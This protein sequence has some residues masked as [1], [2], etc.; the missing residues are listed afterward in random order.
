MSQTPDRDVDSWLPGGLKLASKESSVRLTIFWRVI[1]AQIALIILI[2]AVNFYALSQLNQLTSQSAAIVSR[3][4]AC[5]NEAKRLLQVFLAQMR[6]AEK[7]VLLQDKTFYNHFVDANK[8]FEGGITRLATLIDSRQE[9][10]LLGRI[11]QLHSRYTATLSMVL[12]HHLT[13]HKDR[14]EIGNGIAASLDELIRAREEAI[15]RKMASAGDQ[16]SVAA[17]VVTWLTFGG[18]SL[19]VIFAYFHARSV[20]RPLKK[21][22]QELRLVGRGEFRRSLDIHTPEEVGE[23]SRAFNWM[24]ARLATLDEMK[25]AFIAHISHELRTPLTA[26]REGTT[27]L[28]EEIPGPLT[29]SQR[30]I[31]NVLRSHSERLYRFL[32]SVLDLSKM[33]AGM[34]EYVRLPSDLSAI[35]AR[36]VQTMQLTAQRKGI[37][38]EVVNPVPLPPL[39]LDEW[40]MEQVLDNL[41]HNAMKFTSAGGL[42]QVTASVRAQERHPGGNR[43]VELRVSDTGAGVPA[44][45]RERIFHK[46]YQS[47]GLPTQ[48]DQGTGLGL[49]ITRH[50]VEAHGGRIWVESQLGEGSTFVVRLPVH[51]YGTAQSIAGTVIPSSEIMVSE[52]NPLPLN[53][54]GER[55]AL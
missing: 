55:H 12:S 21:L 53:A 3:D 32:S 38:L 43:W 19:A 5:V 42:V 14:S 31:V 2:V 47:P 26:I 48:R 13:A 49:A 1:L 36:S 4:L 34:M 11:R 39:V 15:A 6:N 16:A 41:L 18:I 25:E 50:I 30:E 22:A 52:A 17:S 20:T 37:R 28:W 33:E 51:D 9:Q 27:L 7:F 46:F 45:E 54:R 8:D 29:P 40:R 24:A 23:L 35:L 10:D 44:E